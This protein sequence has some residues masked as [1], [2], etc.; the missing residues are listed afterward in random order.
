VTSEGRALWF[1][2]PREVE[3]RSVWLPPLRDG[4]VLV[5][6]AFSGISAGSEMLAY[7]GQLDPEMVLDEAI[8]ALGGT[9]RYPFPYGYSCVGRIEATRADGRQVGELVFAFH[10]HQ[11]RFVVDASDV[12]DLPPVDA[13]VATMLPFVETALQVT[14]DAGPVF[15]QTVVVV[16]MGVLG[17]LTSMLLRRGGARVIGVEPQVWRREVA[18]GVG[19]RAVTPEDAVG[20]VTDAGR[21]HG[22]PLVVEASGNPAALPGALQLLAH[23]GTVLVASWYGAQ[24]VLVP[25]GDRFHRR[26]L[27]IRSTQVST[28]PAA[29]TSTWDRERRRQAAAGLLT[30]LPMARLAT[31]TVPFEQAGAAFAAID[32]GRAGLLHVALGYN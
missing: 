8:G 21:T 25:L 12:I 6:T 3:I 23:E 18:A 24:D 32:A 26:R 29:L 9:F 14:L 2:G 20:A 4:E 13:R 11:D 28:I 1:V 7:R 27:T 5:R 17:L 31:D 15:E 22:V 30:D 19:I 10:P 16:G